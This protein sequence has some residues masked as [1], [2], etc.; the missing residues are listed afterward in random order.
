L[1]AKI[2][3]E[4]TFK[5]ASSNET[6]KTYLSSAPADTRIVFI[7]TPINEVVKIVQK[8]PGKG[9]DETLRIIIEDLSK[10]VH[11]S[12][13][14][15]PRCLH[16]LVPPFLRLEPNWFSTRV[17][18]GV[19]YVKDNI[20]ASSPWNVVVASQ[21]DII[22]EDLDSDKIH[23]NNNGKKKLYE[24][25]EGDI[26]KCKE[27][28]EEEVQMDWASQLGG[29]QEPPTPSTL[30]KRQREQN[31]Q[32]TES[33]EEDGGR[34]KARLDSVLDKL[35]SLVKEIKQERAATKEEITS[36]NVHVEEN[37]I[38]VQEIKVQVSDIQSSIKKNDYLTA[39][40]RQDIDGLE[41]ENL[42]QVVV[43]RKLKAEGA[44]PK[45]QKSLRG[46]IQV[47]ARA[48]VSKFA[49]EG[50]DW[51]KAVKFGA[52]L[53]S[54]VDPTKKDNQAG[55]VPPFKIGFDCKESAV[56]FRDA[57]LKKA[58]E[59]GSEYKKTYFAFFQTAGT[60]VRLMLMWS[61][62]ENIRTDTKEAW[63]NQNQPKPTLQ[64][65]EGGKIVESLCFVTTMKK[66]GDKIP[67]KTIDEATKLAKKNFSGNLKETF[68]VLK[69]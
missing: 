8:T 32:E 33:D 23:L 22:E 58:K 59:D 60:R 11:A 62:A 44:V 13:A 65:K 9:R 19:F 69:D 28:L 57:A 42:K 64:V 66:Y 12:A 25:L 38:A 67:K 31:S 36:I 56:K 16:V 50:Q 53:Y 51:A 5:M 4:P 54:F 61:V 48:L 47:V 39:E 52:P 1:T 46:Y 45:D 49:P 18:L 24:A 6:I 14:S 30:R 37:K 15:R 3:E 55:L 63:I 43:V 20:K 34:K 2:G 10:A 26:I 27:S 40:M 35:D 7:M 68:V 29:D 17:R 41:N 21:I